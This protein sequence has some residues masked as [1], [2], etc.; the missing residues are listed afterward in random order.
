[1]EV[2]VLRSLVTVKRP[3]GREAH[4]AGTDFPWGIDLPTLVW[5]ADLNFL[6]QPKVLVLVPFV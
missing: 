1:M 3:V 6:P 5:M 4:T 2:N